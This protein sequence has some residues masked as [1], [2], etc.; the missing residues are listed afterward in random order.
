[1]PTDASSI[2]AMKAWGANAVRVP[3]NEDCWLALNG[4]PPDRSGTNYVNAVMTY[5]SALNSKGLLV[6]LDLH[7]NAPGTDPA[8]S[9]QPM[10][11]RDHAPDLWRG[12][13]QAFKDNGSVL[14]ELYNEPHPDSGA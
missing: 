11:D 3:L 12:V 1:G 8:T 4:A 10:A 9:Q 14:F 5:V 2:D 6:I 13:A 7:W